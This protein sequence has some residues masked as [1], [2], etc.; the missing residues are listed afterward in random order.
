V[1]L[2]TPR[3]DKK[4]RQVL[5]HNVNETLKKLCDSLIN[6]EVIDHSKLSNYHLAHDN[7]HLNKSGTSILA[8]SF[9]SKLREIFNILSK[10]SFSVDVHFQKRRL[11]SNQP[12]SQRHFSSNH[13]DFSSPSR[14]R[15]FGIPGNHPKEAVDFSRTEYGN[16]SMYLNNFS[17]F[18]SSNHDWFHGIIKWVILQWK[19]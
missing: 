8:R 13:S 12:H 4:I 6:V 18:R 9:S 14:F 15:Q 1:S 11:Y 5:S 10:R 16:P 3:L 2:A 7:I 19:V 17:A